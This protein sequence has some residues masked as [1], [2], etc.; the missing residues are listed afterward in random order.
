MKLDAQN[1]TVTV[2]Y[3]EDVYN[4]GLIAERVNWLAKREPPKTFEAEVKV[5]ANH[6]AAEAEIR[7]NALSS[8]GERDHVAEVTFREPQLAI[9]PGQAAVFYRGDQVLGGGWITTV[10][11]G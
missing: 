11:Q 3:K 5:R 8:D 6:E 2:G 7:W 4:G 9:T 1:N 10:T